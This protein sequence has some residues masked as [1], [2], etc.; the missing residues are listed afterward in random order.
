MVQVGRLLAGVLAAGVLAGGL[1]GCAPGGVSATV[2]RVVDGDTIDAVVDGET[3]RVRLL[4]IDTPETKDPDSDVECLGPEASAYLEELLPPGTP[5]KLGYDEERVDG[6]GRVLAGVFLLDGRLV[7]A[8]MARAGL[9]TSMVVGGNDL[10][11]P[12][13]QQAQDD[14]IAARRGFYDPA[15]GCT[16]PGQVQAVETAL[17]ATTSPAAG[18]APAEYDTA[19]GQATAVAAAALALQAK[20]DLPSPRGLIWA[21]NKADHILGNGMRARVVTTWRSADGK[22]TTMRTSSAAATDAARAPRPDDRDDPPA[23]SPAPRPKPKPTGPS[24]SS[25]GSAT[26]PKPRGTAPKA[27][28]KPKPK[29]KPSGGSGAGSGGSSSGGSG[30]GKYTGPR[31]YAPGGKTWKPC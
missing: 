14:A 3:Q 27:T 4:N 11:L 30:S 31:C 17:A 21:A 8:E 29:P 2:G 22:A 6:Y 26:P 12:Q 28:P 15:I 5:I 7:N 16:V 1:S 24:S 25:G 18:A 13:V 23:A 19:A 20:F 9:A 10:F